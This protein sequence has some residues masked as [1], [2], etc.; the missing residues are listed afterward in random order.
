VKLRW[1]SDWN[2]TGNGYGYS[3][4][5]RQLRAAL[6]AAGHQITEDADVAVHIVVPTG[7]EPVPGCFNVL[8]TMYEAT[9]LP[10]EWI[11]PLQRAD[12]IVVPCRQNRSLFKQYTKRPVEVVWEG[13]D[14]D[15][16]TY[17]ERSRPKDTLFTFLYNGAANPRKGYER[18]IIAWE[19]MRQNEPEVFAKSQIVFKT[20]QVTKPPRLAHLPI[21]HVHFD[22]RNYSRENLIKLYHF[23]N[24]FCLPSMGEGFGLTLAEAMATGLPCVYTPWGGPADFMDESV[25][26]PVKWDVGEVR[27]IKTFPDGHQEP[28]HSTYAA[29]ARPES[30]M[31]RMVQIFYGYELALAKGRK[32]AA[33]IRKDFTWHRS[34]ESFV[35]V[36]QEAYDRA[37]MKAAS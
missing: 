18:L 28:Y 14:V 33:R 32:A 7:F 29:W 21:G 22:N 25:A 4:H 35:S 12:L 13:V 17:I 10:E 3:T 23:A 37:G 16:Y 2:F 6:E 36:V 5:Q 34:A 9:T 30:V 27:T 15:A 11:A 20:T 8:Y 19:L 1:C 24:A 31:Q 26:Y